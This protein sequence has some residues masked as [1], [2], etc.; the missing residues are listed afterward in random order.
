MASGGDEKHRLFA[1]SKS[2]SNDSLDDDLFNNFAA[3][4]CDDLLEDSLQA[5][6][7]WTRSARSSGGSESHTESS[8]NRYSS[9][10]EKG[11]KIRRSSESRYDDRMESNADFQD[12]EC[13][14]EL[15]PVKII[16]KKP[17][18]P[19]PPPA[20]RWHKPFQR[21]TVLG[22]LPEMPELSSDEGEKDHLEDLRTLS[23]S[24]RGHSFVAASSTS[25]GGFSRSSSLIRQGIEEEEHRA[26]AGS[27]IKA[28]RFKH[29]ASLSEFDVLD[30]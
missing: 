4:A 13:I 2:T 16:T 17:T 1:S 9:G 24:T 18:G 25:T 19:P 15:Q 11:L 30:L 14:S 5:K 22:A 10:N 7:T 28:I 12:T 20:Q 8:H 21:N 27:A 29:K 26:A 23:F 3:D 6:H